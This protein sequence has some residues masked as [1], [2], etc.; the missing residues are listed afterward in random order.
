MSA[1]VR[2]ALLAVLGLCAMPAMAVI[3]SNMPYANF[4]DKDHEIFKKALEGALDKGADGA[5]LEWS[6]PETKARG[7]I[8]PL[9][10]FERA[11]A[12][13]RTVNIENHAKGLSASAPWTLCKTAP[14]KWS[15]VPAD[16][17]A[18]KDAAKKP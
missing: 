5:T 8:K 14:D 10:T 6:N 7:Q 12:P 15:V 17:P 2:R 3:G 11:G 1:G 18:K 4:T 9:K 13:C 16:P